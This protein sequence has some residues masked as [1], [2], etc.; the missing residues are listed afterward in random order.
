MKARIAIN[1]YGNLGRGVE[2][3]LSLCPDMELT[4]IFTRRD[5]ASIKPNT[6]GV[7]VLDA[8]KA[9][10]Y[11][12][13]ID[14]MILCGGSA[15]DLPVQGPAFAANF[16]TIDSFDTHADIPAYYAKMDAALKASGKLGIIS[17]GWD[18][19][20]FSVNRM[21]AGAI[22]PDGQDYTFWGRGVSQ[23]HSDAIRRIKGVKKAVQYTVPVEEAV[24]SVRSG[25]CPTLTTRDK[26]RRECYV[27]LEEGADAAA[28]TE[29]IV[30][31]PKYFADYNT[32]VNF[33]SEEEFDRNHRAMP[34]GGFVQRSAHTAEGSTQMIE[35]SLKLGSN[36]AFTGSVLVAYARAALKMAARGE[37]GCRTVFD[38]APA[39]LSP[40]SGEELRAKLL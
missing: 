31:M 15:T 5:P 25:S 34:H 21:M 36:P 26:H 27:V 12:S 23:G 16:H 40:L 28:V 3:A 6:P 19:G 33:I 30:T 18:P 2:A 39:L 17:V 4:A 9:A 29:A 32:T 11:A 13:E 20:L 35:F 10:D 24:A 37:S 38:V 7:R 8:A 22:L 1:G 14:L